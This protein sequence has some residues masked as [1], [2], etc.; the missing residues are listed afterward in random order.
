M[1]LES[2]N[3]YCEKIFVYVTKS[4]SL[5]KKIINSDKRNL[6]SW[7][8]SPYNILPFSTIADINQDPS[9]FSVVVRRKHFSIRAQGSEDRTILKIPGSGHLETCTLTAQLN[10]IFCSH[11][12]FPT[13]NLVAIAGN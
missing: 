5:T 2:S 9:V 7:A 3:V 4:I 11:A 12:A 13:W 1:L 8:S 6:V 10:V